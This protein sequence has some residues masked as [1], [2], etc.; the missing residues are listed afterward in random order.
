[1]KKISLLLALI[2]VCA[3]AVLPVSAVASESSLSWVIDDANAFT[4]SERNRLQAAGQQFY[5]DWG[6]HM[7]VHTVSSRSGTLFNYAENYYAESDY[8]VGYQRHGIL[9]VIDIGE[10][11]AA[12]YTHGD[13][14]DY[15]TNARVEKIFDNMTSDM[16]ANRYGAAALV[17]MSDT[18]TYVRNAQYPP[19]WAWVVTF[20]VPVLIVIIGYA[21]VKKRY[22]THP[23]SSP[24]PLTERSNLQLDH[25]EDVLVNTTHTTRVIQTSS[26]SGGGGGGGGRSPSGRGGG[27]GSRKF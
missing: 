7:V 24:Y 4:A 9:L 16:R 3:L 1:M 10:R 6:M 19:W 12:I 20:L 22:S 13:M 5:D 23:T 18:N 17:F 27:G 2:L 25:Q 26:S 21:A 15:V 8:G 14:M 11:E